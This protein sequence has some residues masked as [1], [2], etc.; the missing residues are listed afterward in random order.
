MLRE[1]EFF[2]FLTSIKK[3]AKSGH[4]FSLRVSRDILRRCRL[5]ERHLNIQLSDAIVM[6]A[7]TFDNL[8]ELI[9]KSKV[10][11]TVSNRYGYNDCIHAIRI[12]REFLMTKAI[13]IV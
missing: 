10:G 8:I 4:L 2:V 9:K 11:A 7:S 6:D 5:V 12:Y 3:S 13:E 1:T